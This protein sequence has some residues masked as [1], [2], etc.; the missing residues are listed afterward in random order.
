MKLPVQAAAILRASPAGPIGGT[1]FAIEPSDCK[2]CG[3]GPNPCKGSSPYLVSCGSGTCQCCPT[4][5]FHQ[6]TGGACVC[7]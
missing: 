6:D 4:T 2:T 5:T 3:H 7:G 1:L